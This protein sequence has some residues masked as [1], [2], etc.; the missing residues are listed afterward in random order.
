M[1][2]LQFS[3]ITILLHKNFI[4]FLYY[5]I[6][7]TT[8][9][10]SAS[11]CDIS[12]FDAHLCRPAKLQTMVSSRRKAQAWRNHH[13]PPPFTGHHRFPLPDLSDK[14]DPKPMVFLLHYS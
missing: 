12:I 1:E 4:E 2:F 11:L 5:N 14:N 8:N 10:H 13:S 3:V 9:C 6:T 7:Y